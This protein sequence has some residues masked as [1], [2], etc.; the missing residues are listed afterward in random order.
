MSSSAISTE[1]SAL[2]TPVPQGRRYITTACM[3]VMVLASMEQTV[4]STAMPT[5][6]GQLHGLEHYSWVASLYLL[7]CTVSMPLYGRLADTLG[8][9]RVL[10]F[11]IGL[12]LIASLLASTANSMVQLIL[13]RGLQGIG[14]GGIMPTVLTL[15]ADIF[16]L[17]ERAKIQGLFSAIWGTSSLAG[18]ALGALLVKT[19]GWRSIFFINLPPGIIAA[20][21]IWIYYK[22]HF[23]MTEHGDAPVNPSLSD[24]PRSLNP[25]AHIDLPGFIS[26]S[27]ASAS[28]LVALSLQWHWIVTPA[29]LV[30]CA[31]STTFFVRHERRAEDPLLPLD[32]LSSATIAPC[33]IGSL[34]LGIGFLSLDT[35]VPL[36]VQGGR[37]GDATAAAGVVTP[38]MLAW[39]ISGVFSAPLV[40]K[41]GFRKTSI[42]GCGM[43]L[44]GF[45]GLIVCAAFHWPMWVLTT[46]LA[47]TG[48]GFG[49]ASMSYLLAAQGAVDYFQRGTVTSSIQ[50]TRTLGGAL[51]IG[52]L[53]AL[54]NILNRPL[55][56]HFA[57]S[58]YAPAYLLDP[59][60]HSKL[61]ADLLGHAQS[62]M[63][64]NLVWVF[65]GMIAFAVIQ[66]VITT[67]MTEAKSEH[68][69][70]AAEA[71]EAM[72][73]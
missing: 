71:M 62:V 39:A 48:L 2:P 37:G 61:P 53:G 21:V 36:Y 3:L 73:G 12:F 24:A 38:V 50:L 26:L 63:S 19:M 27:I 34:L 66:I 20:V 57:E 35:Y 22:D 9:K 28:L 17:E 13:Y 25:L 30:A 68:K 52:L 45:T 47:I 49:P 72:A 46:T 33:L 70:N 29:L 10:L 11:S 15:L 18:P 55:M 31:L 67:R 23:G 6:I 56:A 65:I 7:A 59:K 69:I 44:V 40:V 5:I 64:N 32:L 1:H 41:W 42:L 51:G 14:A 60:M 58:G 16:T 4:T 8:R 43:I 54:L